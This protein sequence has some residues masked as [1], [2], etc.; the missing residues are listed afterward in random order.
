[1]R[2]VTTPGLTELARA[3]RLSWDALTCDPAEKWDQANP[4]RGQCGVSTLV[5]HDHLGGAVVCAEV[6]EEGTRT[7]YHYW[8]RLQDDTDVDL[9]RDQFFV[10]EYVSTGRVVD[11]ERGCEPERC[12]AQY[13][14]LRD[15]VEK[16]LRDDP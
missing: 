8:N 5:I 11:R 1:M 7:G 4:G 13:R 6:H 3:I 16:R 2:W 14:R 15:R 12:L 9:T 10:E